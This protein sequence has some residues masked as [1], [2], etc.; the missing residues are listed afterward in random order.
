M[1]NNN[2]PRSV[3]KTCA[4]IVEG[5]RTGEIRNAQYTA[6]VEKAG[7]VVGKNYAATAEGIRRQ[8]VDA[9]QLNL[10]NR[11]EYPIER[12]ILERGIPTS[13]MTFRREQRKYCRALAVI[14]RL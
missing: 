12:L 13:Y 4:G 9:V 11:K 14:L 3:V 10:I 5:V 2:L 8:L 1:S 7:Q 6:A